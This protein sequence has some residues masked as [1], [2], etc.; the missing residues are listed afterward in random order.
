MYYF[1][2]TDPGS[3]R[4]RGSVRGASGPRARSAGRSTRASGSAVPYTVPSL[5]A[6]PTGHRV[7]TP[8]LAWLADSDRGAR[9][10]PGRAVVS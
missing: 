9:D 2:L 1:L 4:V 8:G 5:H 7:E 10:L 6:H 3:R